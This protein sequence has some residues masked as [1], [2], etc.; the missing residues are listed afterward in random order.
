MQKNEV[1][2]PQ[3][4][5]IVQTNILEDQILRYLKAFKAFG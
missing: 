4:I 1:F 2:K 3:G 5:I